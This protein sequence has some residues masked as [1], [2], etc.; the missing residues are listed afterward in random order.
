M[1]MS[2]D[3]PITDLLSSKESTMTLKT[4][5]FARIA[6]AAQFCIMIGV[7]HHMYLMWSQESAATTSIIEQGFVLIAC[8]GWLGHGLQNNDSKLV[9]PQIPA[10]PL[11]LTIIV[12]CVVYS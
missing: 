10:I 5:P 6:T 4:F 7:L 12:M 8:I 1:M 3:D 2:Y 11:A 9:L